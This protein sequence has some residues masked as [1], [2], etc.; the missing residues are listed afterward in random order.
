[1]WP[2]TLISEPSSLD[3]K[4]KTIHC[5]Q[6][7]ICAIIRAAIGNSI[8]FLIIIVLIKNLNGQL[9]GRRID[10]AARERINRRRNLG[11]KR[12]GK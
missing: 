6:L 5:C 1:M 10:R 8:F 11:L 12:R 7:L 4:H 3:C 9:L 2:R